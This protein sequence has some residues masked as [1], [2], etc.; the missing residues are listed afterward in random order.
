MTSPAC[1]IADLPDPAL[2]PFAWETFCVTRPEAWRSSVRK[3]SDERF[4]PNAVEPSQES[5]AAESGV[6]LDCGACFASL[7]ALQSHRA[8]VHGHRNFLRRRIEGTVCVK[9]MRDWG[10]RERLLYH[11]K[12]SA[13]CRRHYEDVMPD[14][15]DSTVANLDIEARPVQRRNTRVGLQVRFAQAPPLRMEG[16][17]PR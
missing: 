13:G 14:L 5:A 7:V 9:C 8:R 16:P 10:S 11:L 2:D 17:L 4:V 15:D 12:K 3:L 1:A 6:C